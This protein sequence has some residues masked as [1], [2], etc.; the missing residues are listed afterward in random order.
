MIPLLMIRHGETSWNAENRLQ[1]HSDIPLSDNGRL[2]VQSWSIPRE[3][4]TFEWVSSPLQRALETARILGYE[5]GIEPALKEMSWGQ[6]EGENW[7]VLQ[8]RLGQDVLANHK[9]G[10]LDFRPPDGESPRDVQTRLRPWLEH[11][12]TPTVAIC[13]KGVLQALYSLLS[14]WS[15]QGKS[16]IKFNRGYACLFEVDAGVPKEVEMNIPLGLAKQ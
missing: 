10:S 2:M 8:T 1:G 11:L 5:P 12:H 14:G 7:R 4:S 15:M 16:P 6:W 9:I 13:H 3:F